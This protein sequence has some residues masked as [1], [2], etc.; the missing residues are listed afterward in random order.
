MNFVPE[1]ATIKARF[2]LAIGITLVSGG[3][4]FLLGYKV[5]A[6]RYYREKAETADILAGLVAAGNKVTIKYETIFVD[7]V[8]KIYIKGNETI[9]EVPVYVT[10]E[11]DRACELRNGF[12]RM[13]DASLRGEA[14]GP[15]ADSDRAAAGIELSRAT[16]TIVANNTELLACRAR[17]D[18]WQKFYGELKS[19]Y[20]Q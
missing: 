15:A 18:G 14:P 8:K 7:R 2:I 3:L 4:G 5:M 17:L 13:Y 11:D 6:E 19:R 20:D 10:K 9:R 1:T 16:E 12:V